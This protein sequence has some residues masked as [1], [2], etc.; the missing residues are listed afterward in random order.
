MS[1]NN[2]QST[3]HILN[4]IR[5]QAQETELQLMNQKNIFL[6]KEF[7]VFMIVT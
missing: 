7:N 4:E 2:L 5:Y 1:N 6:P 3:L